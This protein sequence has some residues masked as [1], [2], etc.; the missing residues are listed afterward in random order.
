MEEAKDE[1]VT[2]SCRIIQV[3]SVYC[4]HSALTHTTLHIVACSNY[5]LPLPTLLEFCNYYFLILFVLAMN[6]ISTGNQLSHVNQL[7]ETVRQQA[8][9]R[10]SKYMCVCFSFCCFQFSHCNT[11][12]NQCCPQFPR[13][14]LAT[15]YAYVLIF[16]LQEL[17]L[18]QNVTCICLGGPTTSQSDCSCQLGYHQKIATQPGT[19]I[20][21]LPW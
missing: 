12:P 13:Q 8:G 20:S 6:Q 18:R 14:S 2:Q 17:C 7:S 11:L 15:M 4:A 16:L 5:T 3:C 21:L 1:F 10:T 9:N 19:Q